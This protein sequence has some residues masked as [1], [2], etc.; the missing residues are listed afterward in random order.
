MNI[1]MTF[2]APLLGQKERFDPWSKF[3]QPIL[4]QEQPE[5]VFFS[6]CL[7]RVDSPLQAAGLLIGNFWENQTDR[8]RRMAK[9]Y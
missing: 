5:A 3:H 9:S 7:Q 1:R 8:D 2:F 6:I 4:P